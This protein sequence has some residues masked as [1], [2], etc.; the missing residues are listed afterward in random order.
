MTRRIALLVVAGLACAS[1]MASAQEPRGRDE[2]KV[3]PVRN[4]LFMLVSSVGNTTVQTGDDG[5]VVVDTMSTPLANSLLATIRTLS[6]K[7]IRLIISSTFNPDRIGGNAVLAAA[8]RKM[9][10]AAGAP[11]RGHQ[12][13]LLR[14]STAKGSTAVPVELWPSDVYIGNQWD[15]F[16]NGEPIL[17]FHAPAAHTDGDTIVLFRRSD[18]ISAG[19]VFS[20]DR[21]PRIDL[22]KGGSINGV[23]AALNHILRLTVP[24]VNQEGGTMV[25]PAHGHLSDE[26]DV[27]DYRDMVTIVRDR[28]QDLVKK[29]MSLEQVKAARLTRDYDPLYTTPQYTGEMFVEAVYRSL[30]KPGNA[31]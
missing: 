22:E 13:A 25:I 24:E 17:F 14:M 16:Y 1:V 6:T 10:G 9:D 2:I 4:N 23:V 11:V 31:R 29:G 7:P 19:E 18:V 3:L 27:A 20:P 8:G 26:A 15:T 28:V 30:G 12:Q 5:V 21:Y